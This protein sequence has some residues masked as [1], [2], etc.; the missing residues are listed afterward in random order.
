MFGFGCRTRRMNGRDLECDSLIFDRIFNILDVAG[1]SRLEFASECNSRDM[2]PSL[3]DI[4]TCHGEVL[5]ALFK[6]PR[7][8]EACEHQGFRGDWMAEKYGRRKGDEHQHVIELL[9]RTHPAE[10]LRASSQ[11]PVQELPY[12]GI[13]IRPKGGV[14][15]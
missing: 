7:H 15:Q 4:F 14:I 8:I 6:G 10:S 3:G 11:A 1:I 5:N 9:P 2:P 13:T 12:N